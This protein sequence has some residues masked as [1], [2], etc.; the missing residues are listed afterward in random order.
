LVDHTDAL[1]QRERTE[2]TALN[3]ITTLLT[4]CFIHGSAKVR[5]SDG[6]RPVELDDAAQ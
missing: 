3:A 4:R 1:W 2:V 6:S 5:V